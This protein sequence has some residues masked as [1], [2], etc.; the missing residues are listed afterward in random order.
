MSGLVQD[1]LPLVL[2]IPPKLAADTVCKGPAVSE[3]RSEETLKFRPSDWSFFCGAT[4]MLMP[5]F[6]HHTAQKRGGK[7]DAIGPVGSDG[8]KVVLTLLT[9]AVTVQVRIPIIKVG[10]PG[11]QRLLSKLC[12][13]GSGSLSLILVFQVGFHEL[14]KQPIGGS[15]GNRSKNW[16][17]WG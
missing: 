8:F 15:S 4:L 5:S 14:L 16:S 11:F 2:R 12:L 1:R 7:R 6:G 3:V 17:L 10:E 13:Y 9:K